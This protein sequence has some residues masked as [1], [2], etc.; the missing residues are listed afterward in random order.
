MNI[1]QLLGSIP[2]KELR[3]K[4]TTS[5]LFKKDLYDFFEH[6]NINNIL[7]IGTNQGWTSLVLSYVSRKVYTVELIEHNRIA[8]KE[9]CK[10]RDNVV[11]IGGDAY[12]DATYKT[13]PKYFDVIVIDCMHEYDYVIK[14]INRGLSYTNPEKGIYLV[15]DDYS[16]PDFPGVRAAIDNCIA[17]GLKVERYIGLSKGN[18]IRTSETNSFELV[19]SE[20]IIL[21]YGK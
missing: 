11:I 19:G 3:W 6:K 20:G 21:S 18:A 14:D 17:S 2:D 4:N 12:S 13:C 5:R 10:D 15:F 16:H 8:A 9:H 1:D 7:E